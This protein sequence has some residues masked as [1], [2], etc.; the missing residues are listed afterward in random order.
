MERY[1][2]AALIF[3]ESNTRL[4][5][6]IIPEG[7]FMNNQMTHRTT[8]QQLQL[9]SCNFRVFAFLF[10]IFFFFSLYIATTIFSLLKLKTARAVA[11]FRPRKL[12]LVCRS[13]FSSLYRLW[14]LFS[15]G[16]RLHHLRNIMSWVYYV[17]TVVSKS[18]VLGNILEQHFFKIKK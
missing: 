12:S 16:S 9:R 14:L 3:I 17:T 15:H 7:S 2:N 18:N 1:V 8:Y 13:R 10:F 4:L 6:F 5:S 11:P